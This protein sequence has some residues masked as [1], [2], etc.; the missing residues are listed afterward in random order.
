MTRKSI[1]M[2]EYDTLI[3]RY[4]ILRIFQANFDDTITRLT[5]LV[6][7]RNTDPTDR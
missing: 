2:T 4:T 6:I 3:V 7:N 1:V 5:Y